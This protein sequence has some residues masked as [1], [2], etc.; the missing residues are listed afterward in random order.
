MEIQT[1][2]LEVRGATGGDE[3]KIWAMDL[4][5]MYLRYTTKKNWQAS[6]VDETTLCIKGERVFDLLKNE[7]GVHRVQRIPTT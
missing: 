5:R 1:I 4:M 3:A 2:Y 6:A 7:A